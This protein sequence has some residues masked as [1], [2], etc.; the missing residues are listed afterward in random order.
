M[1][2][3]GNWKAETQRE[4]R[5]E[6]AH[7]ES[8]DGIDTRK[9]NKGK[10]EVVGGKGDMTEKQEEKS[11]EEPEGRGGQHKDGRTSSGPKGRE[12]EPCRE[13]VTRKADSTFKTA[14]KRKREGPQDSEVNM[15]DRKL[16]MK[17]QRDDHEYS[18]ASAGQGRVLFI[19]DSFP[20]ELMTNGGIQY[21]AWCSKWEFEIG[22]EL[23]MGKQRRWGC[24]A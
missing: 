23:E 1:I 17:R 6:P 11:G 10:E 20:E 18:R 14:L 16:G 9:Q 22:K 13:E 19:G 7:K 4:A 3:T 24:G 8:G 21:T 2:R 12:H 15:E 5:G